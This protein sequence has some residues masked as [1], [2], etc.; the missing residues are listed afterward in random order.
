MRQRRRGFTLIE[1]LVVIA[2]IAIL[3]AILFP[4]FAQARDKARAVACLSNMKQLGLG[5]SMY[6]QDY[7]ES[8]PVMNMLSTPVNGGGRREVGYDQQL[9]PY[10]KNEGIYTCPSDA[11]NRGT[12][13]LNRCNDGALARKL[14]KRSYGYM[15]NVDTAEG[16][17]KGQTPDLNTGMSTLVG[18]PRGHSLAE[19]TAPTDTIAILELREGY[20]GCFDAHAFRNC[21]HVKLL[22]R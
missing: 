1:L 22:G 3:A 17:R 21:D 12:P 4:V 5:L 8:M 2:I 11:V 13:D 15:G 6:V 9:L 14:V 16:Y 19:L 7:D 18:F 20:L 10:V